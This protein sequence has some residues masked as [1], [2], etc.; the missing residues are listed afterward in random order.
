MPTLKAR[1][2]ALES[3]HGQVAGLGELFK[4][5]MEV[6]SR[7][8]FGP[9]AP[10]GGLWKYWAVLP[11]W[12]CVL[13]GLDYLQAAL[14][15]LDE[16]GLTDDLLGSDLAGRMRDPGDDPAIGSGILGQY[17]N[18][19][20]AM[21]DMARGLLPALED[22]MVVLR[23]GNPLAGHPAYPKAGATADQE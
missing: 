4:A 2:E 16:T 19:D 22:Y 8:H 18:Q 20:N 12:W 3:A 14:E 15:I 5:R 11:V 17:E 23:G 10:H 7:E 9:G 21:R 13:C 1:I 6:T